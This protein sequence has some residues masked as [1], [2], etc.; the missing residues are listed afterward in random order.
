[1]DENYLKLK[2]RTLYYDGDSVVHNIN[3]LYDKILK[4][5]S[6]DDI[7]V[8]EITSEIRKYNS[9]SGTQA[10][11]KIKSDYKQPVT[12]WTIPDEYINL[13]LKKYVLER[14]EKEIE[15]NNYTSEEIDKRIDRVQLELKLWDEHDM[16]M[17]LATLIYMVETLEQEKLVWGTGRGSSCCS[18]LLYLIGLH[19][20]DSVY[21]NLDIKEFFKN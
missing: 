16:N 9:L 7:F 6:L 21:Y 3:F 12:K 17:L 1:M 11:L 10:P 18:Y 13:N 8:E 15:S 14:L 5:E 20:V 4:G 2:D 19:D